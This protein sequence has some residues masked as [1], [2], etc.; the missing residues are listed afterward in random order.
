MALK[1]SGQR[2]ISPWGIP[3]I[4][5]SAMAIRMGSA[6]DDLLVGTVDDDE[7]MGDAGQDSLRGAGGN[8]TLMGEAGA[9]ELQGGDGADML[10]DLAGQAN[11]LD[12]GDGDDVLVLS[13]AG[14]L[15]LGADGSMS[16]VH[17]GAGDDSLVLRLDL[18]A[19]NAS[20][21]SALGDLR[22]A[23]LS[24]GTL[25]A[26]GFCWDG[27]E[28]LEWQDSEGVLI[29]QF[30]PAADELALS[31]AE[32]QVASG[33][34]P[35]AFDLE[36]DSVSYSLST[37]AVYG[38]ATVAADG[39][40]VYTP[41]PNYFGIDSFSYQVADALGVRS[42]VV[43][44]TIDAVDDAAVVGQ[45]ISDQMAAVGSTFIFQVPE[46]SFV[47]SDSTLLS[48]SAQLASGAALP[49]WLGFD[50][51]TMT[52]SGTPGPGDAGLL[53][54]LVWAAGETARTSDGFVLGVHSS[55]NA[56]PVSAI[57]ALIPGAVNEDSVLN[58]SLPAAI[59]ADGDAVN[60]DWF[61]QPAHGTVNVTADGHYQ[62]TPHGNYH[63]ADSFVF[64]LR[65]G[66][67]GSTQG[68]QLLSVN[69]QNDP[70]IGTALIV[71]DSD[72]LRVG[73]ELSVIVDASDVDGYSAEDCSYAWLRDGLPIPGA[74]GAT[75]R[76]G[77]GDIG[78][79]I[80]VRVS[81]VDGSGYGESLLAPPTVA[82]PAPTAITGTA[83]ADELGDSAST[84]AQ[85]I[86]GLAGGDALSGGSS[87]DLL[88][89]GEGDDWIASG[90]GR[91]H[92]DA[93][94][95]DD[96]IVVD[97]GSLQAGPHATV[98]RGG[99]GDDMLVLSLQASGFTLDQLIDLAALRADPTAAR[100]YL[101]LGLDV[102]G[103]E[104]L[105]WVDEGGAALGNWAPW[106][107]GALGQT[108][109]DTALAGQLPVGVDVDGDTLSYRFTQLP[110]HGRLQWLADGSYS[111]M[112]E[113]D[114][115]GSDEASYQ[116]F[117]GLAWSADATLAL[118]V[119][120][121][122]EAPR[123]AHGVANANAIV[124]TAL[125]L[126]MPG[127][128]FVDPDAADG[129][130][131]PPLS[132]LVTQKGSTP[133]PAWLSFNPQ[134]LA[135]T[136]TPTVADEGLL[137]LELTA[138]DGVFS[139]RVE[140]ILG[141][142][143]EA[144]A[145]PAAG[146]ASFE[147]AEDQVLS[148]TLPAADD[149]DGDGLSYAWMS[150]P[151]H[152]VLGI[153]ANGNFTYVA[154]ADYFGSDSFEYA[155]QDDRGGHSVALVSITVTPVSDAPAGTVSLYG[156]AHIG[157]V[158]NV[159]LSRLSDADGLPGTLDITWLRNGVADSRDHASGFLL[160]PDD[161][162]STISVSV[163]YVDGGNST[164]TVVSA[165][166][167]AVSGVNRVLGGDGHDSL[168][169]SLAPDHIRGM[170]GN[171]RLSG[172]LHNDTLDGGSGVDSVIYDLMRADVTLAF[173]GWALQA[174][175]SAQGTDTL[176]GIERLV[177]SD[178]ALALDLAGHAGQAA[179]TIGALF[180]ATR[181]TDAALVGAELALLDG[182]MAYPD[183]IAAALRTPLFKQLAGTTHGVVSNTQFVNLVYANVVGAAPS[184]EARSLYVGL[185]NDGSFT[186]ASLA[187][188]ASEHAQNAI[189]ID[190]VGLASHGL[191]YAPPPGP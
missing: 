26:L 103:V 10:M 94:A 24:G 36:G 45:H 4:N 169:G 155:V 3:R 22:S 43:T 91:D 59:D 62:Y 42:H 189:N 117:D 154:D 175:S 122:A 20:A 6:G 58:G 55:A 167:A 146:A 183:L 173:T 148:A 46:A 134:S 9:D 76:P 77:I 83:D 163:S 73:G 168:A 65:D 14:Y 176:I 114:Y 87:D 144:N 123:L 111:Y 104:H 88:R 40:Y 56:S 126:I 60:F 5:E 141:V 57:G 156:L 17:G 69:S 106:A 52:F 93:G 177:F 81:F 110:A 152:G 99:E 90:G 162:G 37:G 124:G 96:T 153:L 186:Q 2:P 21:L 164:E 121:V 74:D 35:L 120:A 23:L 86:D 137:T 171:D 49:A 63:G 34:L 113:A 47:D 170:A 190:L 101:A 27:I 107:R 128:A 66:R 174:Q 70:A 166:S 11:V 51:A 39:S 8:D 25:Q 89:G 97:G 187:M 48:Y 142:H 131:A 151:A 64:E 182:G 32:D 98:V 158:L 19:L 108:A 118:T 44:L 95:G 78:G 138:S 84:Q 115:V 50:A 133:L 85:A 132:L 161:H 139:Q 125:N 140:F 61:S 75:Y 30:A 185:L 41:Q 172:G 157:G 33:T 149:A 181:L 127:D 119:T 180:G 71:L 31:L 28:H 16:V 165:A 15:G 13:F 92:I 100:S 80:S 150:G 82:V 68:V 160:E 191:A 102:A 12:G 184:A 105:Q 7:L 179:R 109:E 145:A 135:L 143:T 178:T 72:G 29:T 147:V 18:N 159:D 53:Q 79:L 136:G 130:D 1:N 116:V 38:T 129:A 112:P 188:A 54:V 67:G